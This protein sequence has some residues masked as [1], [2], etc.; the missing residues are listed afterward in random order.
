MTFPALKKP[1]IIETTSETEGV[2][3]MSWYV[4]EPELCQWSQDPL[5]L[6]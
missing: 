1:H 2:K 3:E 4:E 6:N 5:S